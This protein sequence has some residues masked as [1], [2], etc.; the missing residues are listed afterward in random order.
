MRITKRIS[1][2]TEQ[3]V[4]KSNA[5]VHENEEESEEEIEITS[6]VQDL[7][8]IKSKDTFV[9]NGLKKTKSA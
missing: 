5:G 2:R 7:P 3:V 4:D 9:F 1:T 6:I 8:K